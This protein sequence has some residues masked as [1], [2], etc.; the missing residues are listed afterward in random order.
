M[1]NG[2]SH[3]YELGEFNANFRVVGWYFYFIQFFLKKNLFA[4]IGEPDQTPRFAAS[5]PVL[6]CLPMSQKKGAWL[7]WVKENHIALSLPMRL[8]ASDLGLHCLPMSHKKTLG[9]YG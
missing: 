4:N 5:G 3:C 2:I 7:I 9:L 6:H 8:V 1:T